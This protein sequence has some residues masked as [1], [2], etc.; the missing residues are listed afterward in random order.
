VITIPIW[1]FITF[2]V[3]SAVVV[4]AFLIAGYQEISYLFWT[5]VRKEIREEMGKRR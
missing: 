3:L 1:L 5:A 4:L 2:C